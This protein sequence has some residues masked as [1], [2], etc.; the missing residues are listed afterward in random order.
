MSYSIVNDETACLIEKVGGKVEN[1]PGR[2]KPGAKR[3]FK[4]TF[5][6]S[7]STFIKKNRACGVTF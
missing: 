4:C 5:A 7:S 6:K 2:I 1:S 3:I